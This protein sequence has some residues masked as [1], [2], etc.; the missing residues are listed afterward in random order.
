MQ[1]YDDRG[2]LS[3]SH[4]FK[5]QVARSKSLIKLSYLYLTFLQLM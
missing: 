1:T 2:L 3:S 5:Y 4:A